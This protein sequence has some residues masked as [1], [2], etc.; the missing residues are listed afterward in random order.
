M[1]PGCRADVCSLV[2]GT[3]PGWLNPACPCVLI[4]VEWEV[5]TSDIENHPGHEA[6]I[7]HVFPSISRGGTQWVYMSV[8][9]LLFLQ[10]QIKGNIIDYWI[11]LLFCGSGDLST[12]GSFDA[13]S[14]LVSGRHGSLCLRAQQ[15]PSSVR[16]LLR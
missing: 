2:Q 7:T 12:F 4:H 6:I 10:E 15:V 14:H 9:Y 1:P 3:I 5:G 11:P 16:S 13:V 8:G